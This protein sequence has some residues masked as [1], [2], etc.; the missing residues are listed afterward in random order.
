MDNSK[1]GTRGSDKEEKCIFEKAIS[2]WQDDREFVAEYKMGGIRIFS[3]MEFILCIELE[4][5]YEKYNR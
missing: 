5:S 1:A 3:L 2:K 4:G